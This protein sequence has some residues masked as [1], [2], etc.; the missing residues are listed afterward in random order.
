[1][2]YLR[3]FQTFFQDAHWPLRLI[4]ASLLLVV[5]MIVPLLTQAIFMGWTA[6]AMRHAVLT[7]ELD[8]LPRLDFD[9][10]YWVS[11]ML[12]GLKQV[13]ITLIWMLPVVA[14]VLA[15]TFPMLLA[16]S[17]SAVDNEPLLV[18]AFPCVM[19]CLVPIVLLL[20]VPAQVALLRVELC[21]TISSGF[22]FPEIW[23]FLRTMFFELVAGLV[24][25]GL[26]GAIVSTIGTCLLCI[27]VFPAS[28]LVSYALAQCRAYIYERYL[29]KGGQPW[30]VAPPVAGAYQAAQ[31]YR[32]PAVFE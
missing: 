28:V 19:V 32:D 22:S 17:V 10:D 13:A 21:D 25:V 7:R 11:L 30:Q 27:G 14:L 20:L 16:A 5:S 15:I 26:V 3:G 9:I 8:H 4:V 12:S 31:T 29:E 1:M 2:G 6:M 24:L 23:T 18:A